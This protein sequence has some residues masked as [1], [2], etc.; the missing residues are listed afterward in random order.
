MLKPM[1][2]SASAAVDSRI[3]SAAPPKHAKAGRYVE[4]TC[5]FSGFRPER[6]TK[7]LPEHE[8]LSDYA[9]RQPLPD[10]QMGNAD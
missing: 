4:G 6:R 8:S 2:Q 5:I 9:V 3:A 1:N 10:A 7:P